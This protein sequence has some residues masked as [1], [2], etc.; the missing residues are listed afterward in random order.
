MLKRLTIMTFV[1]GLI[2][3]FAAGTAIAT[4][5]ISGKAIPRVSNPTGLEKV[6]AVE[7][8]P[9]QAFRDETRV[10]VPSNLDFTKT[11][12]ASPDTNA[13]WDQDWTDYTADWYYYTRYSG[14]GRILAL[15][16]DIP[17]GHTAEL[18]G[19]WIC[20]NDVVPEVSDT[21]QDNL[22]LMTLDVWS[23]IGGIPDAIV[24]SE[25]FG[26]EAGSGWYY[27]EWS[28]TPV[29]E[30][31]TN[32]HISFT[33]DAAG[34]YD[35]M[36]Q[37]LLWD[38]ETGQELFLQ[39]GSY[40]HPSNGF[41][42]PIYD[43]VGWDA[44]LC[45]SSVLCVYYSDCYVANANN[46]DTEPPYVLPMPWDFSGWGLPFN[47]KFAQRYVAGNDTLKSVTVYLNVRPEGTGY[48]YGD[49]YCGT[50]ETNVLTIGV[51]PDNGGVPDYGAGPLASRSIGPGCSALFPVTGE[52]R[53]VAS[54]E[55]HEVDFSAD[56]L[57]LR[58]TY[59]LVYEWSSDDPADGASWF[60]VSDFGTGG[61]WNP[62]GTP[63]SMDDG[64]IWINDFWG[65][66]ASIQI[67]AELCRD[68]FQNCQHQVLYVDEA[69][70]IY[71]ISGFKIASRVKG[72]PVNRLDGITWQYVDPSIFEE[73][74]GD[75]E[76]QVVVWANQ[77]GLPGAELWRSSTYWPDDL[78]PYPGWNDLVIPGGLIIVGDF[79]VGYE[80]VSADHEA[81]YFYFAIERGQ[82][83]VNGGVK[84][85]SGGAQA[86][87]DLGDAV[88]DDANGLMA[89]D[90]C[91]I[92]VEELTCEPGT[93]EWTTINGDMARTGHS[94]YALG[95]AWCNLNQGWT[96]TNSRGTIRSGPV[97]SGDYVVQSF[98]TGTSAGY[99]ILD[100]VSGAVLDSITTTDYT[101]IG[102][103]VRCT[104]TI[105]NGVLYVAGGSMASV[106]AFDMTTV[107]NPISQIWSIDPM[108][109]YNSLPWNG[110]GDVSGVRYGNFVI[111][112]DGEIDV[113][114]FTDD[115]NRVFAANASDGT[116]YLGW[117]GATTLIGAALRSGATDGN[118]LYYS[119]FTTGIEGDVVA[120][121][122]LD[123]SI[124]WSLAAGDGLQA[125]GFWGDDYTE[126]SETFAAGVSVDDGV[127]F[128]NSNAAGDFPVQ[129]IFYQLNA[130]TGAINFFEGGLNQTTTHPLVDKNHV[131]MF[132]RY[133]WGSGGVSPLGGSV[134]AFSRQTGTVA[135]AGNPTAGD[136]TFTKW[137]LYEG[138][139]TCEPDG[140]PDILI[141]F[142]GGNTGD[143]GTLAFFNTVTGEEI[144]HRRVDHG[145]GANVGG[146]GAIAMDSQDAI[147][148]LFA[149]AYGGLYD[150]THGDDRARLDILQAEAEIP[151]EFGTPSGAVLT[152]AEIYE[153][154]G[155]ADLVV[156]MVADEASNGT[157]P[158]GAPGITSVRDG[159][160]DA[161]ASIADRLTA[162]SR[163][164]AKFAVEAPAYDD[165]EYI[166]IEIER[167]VN[168]GAMAVPAF[169]IENGTYP[170]DVFDPPGGNIVT[171]P[172]AI[173]D[174]SVY[175]D[176][177]VISRGPQD[178]YVEFTTH[179]DPDYF[180]N[181]NSILPEV[182]LILVGGCLLDT[183][184]LQFGHGAANHQV[185]F[186]T[187]MT[188]DGDFSGDPG[189]FVVDGY[190]ES[191]F[192]GS[193]MF[194]VTQYR[195]AIH[196]SNW[197]G[198]NLYWI[199]VQGDPNWSDGTCK[200]ALSS[201]VS[202]GFISADGLTYEELTGDMIANSFVDSVQNFWDGA[203]W[204]WQAD[205]PFDNDSTMG[206][207]G[208]SRYYGAVDA[209]AV[210]GGA[211]DILNNMTLQITD[212]W[213]RNGNPVPDWKFG[214]I[215]DN[216]NVVDDGNDFDTTW[217]DY[218]ISTGINTSMP[219]P[220][221]QVMYTKIP[222]G[223][224]HEPL[225]NAW[226]MERQQFYMFDNHEFDSMYFYMSVPPNTYHGHDQS[227]ADDQGS[228]YSYA[229]HDFAPSGTFSIGI[230]R[231]QFFGMADQL[232]SDEVIAPAAHLA[233]KLAGFGRGDVNNDQVIDLVDIIYLAE[234]VNTATAGPVPFM[235]LGDVDGVPGVD[236]ADVMYLVD[237]YFYAGAC[238]IGD[239]VL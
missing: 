189:N 98:S 82:P 143:H 58:G 53:D 224:G 62:D 105:H 84:Y 236:Q 120:I 162:D 215:I 205:G 185:V 22:C 29:L 67:H 5:D 127:V 232:A 104:P 184:F 50:N 137:I 167:S 96:F 9:D 142:S 138:V 112:N 25:T 197:R 233:N 43:V 160:A 122:P 237:F 182:H 37:P 1:L 235:H 191:N 219:D 28:T 214:E 206:I 61:S 156:S 113:L 134:V 95:D 55:V 136:G 157:T 239:W 121:N 13:C 200:P 10:L 199:S 56:N 23:D 128:A 26:L 198:L 100:L 231:G 140:R 211:Y 177:P 24:H 193:Q 80:D 172:G 103:A 217:H 195:F 174:I 155:C 101:M 40:F 35:D 234:H 97:V 30:G 46:P 14:D 210:A 111:L 90:I 19:T 209:D 72:Q 221:S 150:L 81:A 21:A 229:W 152:F 153:N 175:V 51:Y 187:L 181:D 69:T 89:V 158:A 171:A 8:T 59:H 116:P 102:G 18:Q 169:L 11:S 204:D 74:G 222:F 124:V 66:S 44:T 15:R 125:A 164:A 27:V 33:H 94:H 147:H 47:N 207:A 118:N 77:S 212:F 194:G 92:P 65:N 178:F 165:N 38:G 230:A 168:T 220:I 42:L 57:I 93:T 75:Y 85:F 36:I 149:D 52:V 133:T 88:G 166:P 161:A 70:H 226:G 170:G 188:G 68:E 91:S 154:T 54:W 34:D 218:A 20:L 202:L 144:F 107:G 2:F 132:S 227:T 49:Y 79:F 201:G 163:I 223:C 216:D 135:W 208:N 130:S 71:G 41:W 119:I 32:Y 76:L 99:Y 109:I 78:T 186:N 117:T 115:G 173:S 129:G 176:G 238:P 16:F 203:E 39:R 131:Y 60:G 17:A 146:P 139:L 45:M 145:A 110:H 225:I 213:E 151:V 48:G 86:W 3:V 31:M 64:A 87:F 106:M 108:T 12:V 196:S 6:K 63:E 148:V 4:D 123:G 228:M 126:N 183:T 7:G 159:F 83:E 192:Q 114:Y 179:N 141:G 180:L 190:T 73:D